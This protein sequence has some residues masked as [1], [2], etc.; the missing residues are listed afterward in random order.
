MND[1]YNVGGGP[2]QAP[3]VII[4]VPNDITEDNG[5]TTL[6]DQLLWPA[7]GAVIVIVMTIVVKKYL[8]KRKK[9]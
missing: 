7:I 1:L 9:K 5:I 6:V 4:P 2:D 8:F 3:I